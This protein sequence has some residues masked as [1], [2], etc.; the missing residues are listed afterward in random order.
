VPIDFAI[1]FQYEMVLISMAL[2]AVVLHAISIGLGSVILWASWITLR[3]AIGVHLMWWHILAI[4][5]GVWLWHTLFVIR[6]VS[7]HRLFGFGD[8]LPGTVPAWYLLVGTIGLLLDDVALWLI[9][10][11]QRGRLQLQ[12][13]R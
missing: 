12:G 6:V 9:L 2:F 1:D 5:I 13:K 7:D 11:V 3:P 4:T 10:K 8:W